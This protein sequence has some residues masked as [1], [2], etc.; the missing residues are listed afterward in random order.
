MAPWTA[1]D[2]PDQTGRTVIVT[3]ANSGLGAELTR[4]LAR[5]GATVVM[6]CRDLDKARALADAI[7]GDIRLRRLDLADLASVRTFADELDTGADVLINNAGVMAV[8]E[9]TTADGFERHLGT[10]HLG[11][12]ALTG[13]L[14]DRVRDRVVTVSSGLHRL[15]GLGGDLLTAFDTDRGRYQRWI[16]YGRSKL[17]NLLFAY[18]LQRRLGTAG[19]PLLSVAAH[20]G[21]A[22]TEGQRRDT[23]LQGKFLAGGKA[24]SPEMGALP[25]LYAATAPGVRG[26]TCIGPDGFAQRK[27]HPAVVN[28]SRRSRDQA[29]AARLWTRSEAATGITYDY[30][31]RRLTLAEVEATA[32]AAHTGQT[33]KA[34]RPYAGH[35]QAVAEGT[36][37]RGGSDEQIAA[38][39]LHDAIEDDALSSRWLDEAPLSPGTKDIVRALTKQ[40]GEDPGAYADR[41]LATDGARLVKAAD[42]A[43]NADPARL[44]ALD[45]P[46]RERLTRKYADMRARLGLGEDD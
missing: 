5:S 27:G 7:D 44:A 14:L 13:L 37:A 8:P 35:L 31:V 4:A 32:R 20:P 45:G 39:W 23:S 3:G 17:A 15:A 33:D 30:T 25:L 40:P 29:L 26:G 2:A 22:G 10:N 21:V 36:R 19:R 12:Y 42:L 28:T 43:H 34:G 6:A 46:T 9:G 18:E 1:A 24:Q 41:I 38:A 11:P 16:A